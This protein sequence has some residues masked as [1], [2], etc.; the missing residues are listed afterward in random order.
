[1]KPS[2]KLLKIDGFVHANFS[3]TY[4]HKAIDDPACVISITGNVNMVAYCHI[5]K[6][7]ELQS[8]TALSAM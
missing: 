7:S 2:E 4:V 3:E 8:E 1:M 5:M 6:Q